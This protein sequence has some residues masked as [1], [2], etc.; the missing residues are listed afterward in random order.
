M[1]KALMIPGIGMLLEMMLKMVG[2][3][4]L[5]GG[6]SSGRSCIRSMWLWRI[7][8]FWSFRTDSSGKRFRPTSNCWRMSNLIRIFTVSHSVW[9]GSSLFV[10]FCLIRIFTVCHSVW[11]GSSLF[12]IL[13]DQDLDCLPFCL[14]RILT[15]C[16][17]VWSGS[18]LFAIL[19][20]QDLDC[21]PFCL[22]RIFTVC[23][24]VWSGYSLF[25]ILSDQDLH[26]LPFCLIRIFTV[27][28]F[29][30]HYCMVK[31]QCSN[32]RII[33]VKICCNQPKIWTKR[34][35]QRV[36]HPKDAAGIAKSVDPDLGAVWSGSALFAQTY[37]FE[38]LGSLR[39]SIFFVCSNSLDFMIEGLC[40]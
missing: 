14:I 1:C 6:A 39:Y 34:L 30:I 13:S 32:F 36:M 8:I 12:A 17:S 38:N 11:S 31:P 33:T 19:S 22:I 24:S 29:W 25:A 4:V 28:I 10:P 26:C 9:S 7:V 27:C 40:W 21:L 23:H 2:A 15:V 20:D 16:H 18:S 35:Y 37:L 5:M 3:Q